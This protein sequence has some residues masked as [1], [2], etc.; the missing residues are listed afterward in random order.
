MA[1]V[2]R[3]SGLSWSSRA[4]CSA[5]ELGVWVK[6]SAPD[7]S[8]QPSLV[9]PG[10]TEPDWGPAGVGAAAKPKLG[11]KA[12]RKRVAVSVPCASACIVQARLIRRGK[13]IANKRTTLGSAGTARLSLKPKRLK[14]GAKVTVRATVTLADGSAT[15]LQKRLSAR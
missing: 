11:A 13:T 1:E 9:I 12:S 2:W 6:L 5:S 14:R 7:C 3:G 4:G 10:A 15:T 8:V